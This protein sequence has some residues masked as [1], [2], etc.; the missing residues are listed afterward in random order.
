MREVTTTKTVYTWDELSDEAKDHA[1]AEHNSFLW[2]SGEMRETMEEI[3]EDFLTEQGWENL[4]GLSYNLYSPGGEPAWDGDLPEWEFE[5]R[6]YY[7]TVRNHHYFGMRVSVDETFDEN[8]AV[9]YSEVERIEVAAKDMVLS[10]SHDLLVKMRAEDEY[11]VNDES[12]ADTC[13]ANGYEFDEDGN[14]V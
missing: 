12:M 4:S 13:E 5:G 6:T 10:L 8:E 11:V 3:W 1:R 7:V 9:A 14:L 2:D